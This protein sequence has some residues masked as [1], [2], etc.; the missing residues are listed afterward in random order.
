M[1]E[2]VPAGTRLPDRQPRP[3]LTGNPGPVTAAPAACPFPSGLDADVPQSPR[4]GACSM[5]EE[6]LN[7]WTSSHY[8]DFPAP[9]GPAIS[10]S[11]VAG[12][13]TRMSRLSALRQ[14]N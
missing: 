1:P 4:P 8:W 9:A 12:P 11:D 13:V 10:G 6:P 2:Q 7:G 3:G 5:S 14:G